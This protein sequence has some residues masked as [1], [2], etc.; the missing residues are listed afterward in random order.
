MPKGQILCLIHTRTAE[1]RMAGIEMKLTLKPLTMAL[2]LAFFCSLT[3]SYQ[4]YRMSSSD[5][6]FLKK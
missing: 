6:R 1:N 2:K 5:M 4:E 3:S